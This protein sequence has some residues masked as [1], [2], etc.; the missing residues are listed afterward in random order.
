MFAVTLDFDYDEFKRNVERYRKTK[1]KP[2]HF[3]DQQRKDI[4][5]A[6]KLHQVKTHQ[7]TSPGNEREPWQ[8]FS[9]G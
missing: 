2:Y 1:T 4:V 5:A 8:F 9:I 7:L 6:C 3:T